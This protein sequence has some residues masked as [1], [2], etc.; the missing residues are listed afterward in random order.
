MAPHHQEKSSRPSLQT[1]YIHRQYV[2]QLSPDVLLYHTFNTVPSSNQYMSCTMM[3]F[4]TV[5]PY[6]QSQAYSK[7][8]QKAIPSCSCRAGWVLGWQEGRLP[9]HCTPHLARHIHFR[10][11]NSW[12]SHHWADRLV[13]DRQRNTMRMVNGT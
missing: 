7:A 13:S 1:F 3:K 9:S 6:L 5:S 8:C 4:S 12:C 2:S 11:N 10:K